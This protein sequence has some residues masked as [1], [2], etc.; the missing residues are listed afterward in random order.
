MTDW[1]LCMIFGPKHGNR[2]LD[3]VLIYG[4]ALV[5]DASL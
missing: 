3:V 5:Q 2:A 1:G 4:L